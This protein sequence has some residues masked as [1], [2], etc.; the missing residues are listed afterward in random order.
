M[1]SP[2]STLDFYILKFINFQVNYNIKKIWSI[3]IMREWKKYAISQLKGEITDYYSMVLHL[4]YS[5]SLFGEES[6]IDL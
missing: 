2:I 3:F 6:S 5:D 1:I 4:L